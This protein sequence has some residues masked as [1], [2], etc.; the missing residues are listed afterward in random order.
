M[1]GFTH[2]EFSLSAKWVELLKEIAPGVKRAAVI[3]DPAG[4]G[5]A[6]FGAIQSA[7]QSLGVEVSPVNP[8]DAHESSV[9]SRLSRAPRMAA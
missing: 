9:A 6:Q 2:F 4:S 3:R 7:A 1:T 8:R 5:L